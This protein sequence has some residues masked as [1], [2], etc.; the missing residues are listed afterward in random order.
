MI[1][2]IRYDESDVAAYTFPLF[3]GQYPTYS[4]FSDYPG[5]YTYKYPKAGFANSK[6]EVRTF[7]IKSRVTRTMKVPVDADGYIP[8]IHFT[9]DAT[10]LAV[11]TLNRH[12]NRFELYFVDPRSTVAKM[13]VRDEADT[14]IDENVLDNVKFYANGFGMLSERDG[15]SHLYWYAPSGT[16]QKQVTKGKFEVS[17]FLG[18]DSQTGSFFVASNEESPMRKAIYKI[19]RNGKKTKLSTQTGINT[20]SFSPNMKYFINSYTNLN[21]PNLTTL[22]DATTGKV[23]KT[24]VDN[25][26][27]KGKLAEVN[28]PQKEFFSFKTAEGVELNGWMMK[29]TDFDASKKYPVVMY[30]YSGPGSQN[31][32]DSY[33]VSW[34]TYMATQGFVMVCVDGRGTGGRGAAFRTCTYM[35][36]G[37]KEADDQVATAQ[38]LGTLPYVDKSRIGIWGWSFGGYATLMSMSQGTPVFKAGV[39]VAAPTDWRFYDTIYTERYMRTPKENAEGYK[40]SSAFER[41]DKLS[42]KLLLVHGMADDNVHFQ[43]CAE[44]T[45]QL[46]Q[47]GKQFDMQVYTNRNHSIFGGNTRMHLYTR[48]TEYFKNNL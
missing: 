45:E 44:Y 39:A 22:V 10:K 25:K 48:I 17:E 18:Y 34:E 13:V 19:D 4:D 21:T 43:N 27:L 20:A 15:Y 29:P 37:V 42:G 33:G 28:I 46:V 32:L 3:K 23:V 8:R 14:Y 41:A 35:N 30:Q 36:L 1:A 38:Y 12:Q 31:V 2:F 24:L 40:A 11:M 16:L 6:V 26:E 9:D 47:L 5:S 7:D